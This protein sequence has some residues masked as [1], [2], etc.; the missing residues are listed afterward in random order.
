MSRTLD[1]ELAKVAVADL[2]NYNEA[3]RTYIIP[4]FVA[5]KL[6]NGKVY[7]LKLDSSLLSIIDN[8]VAINW[9][10]G[11]IPQDSC[12]KAQVIKTIG[13]MVYIDGLAF[14]ET[15]NVDLNRTWSG[16]LPL[17]QIKMLKQYD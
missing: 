12:Y 15:N 2:S 4:K 3:T 6:E 13:K 17:Q 5:K 8:V 1:K 7:L 9:N 10:R 14:D 16:W 11:S